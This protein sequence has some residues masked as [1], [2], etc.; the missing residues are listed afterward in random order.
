VTLG[1]LLGLIVSTKGIMV[2]PLKVKE[3]V[4]F[5]PPHTIPQL[6]SLQGKENFLWCFVANNVDI[7]KGLMRLLKKGVP[8]FW[9]EPAQ[10]SFDA[11]KCSLTFSPLVS[12]LDYGKDFLLYLGI[13]E[14]TIFMVL[15]QEDYALEEHVIYYLSQGLVGPELNYSHV[16]KLALVVVHA[17]QCFC[18]YISLRKTTFVF[19]INP[20]QYG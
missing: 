19:I 7:T 6:Q 4:Q 1:C 9:D 17:I 20:F 2:D 10:C 16:A 18:H 13:A 12:P 8:F 15:F 11:L 14:S 5:P 3:I